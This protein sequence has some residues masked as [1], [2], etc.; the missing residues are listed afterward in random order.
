MTIQVSTD[1][2]ISLVGDCPSDDA[3]RLLQLLLAKPQAGLDWRGCETA[4]SA[5]IQ[6]LLQSGQKPKGPAKGLFLRTFL[7]PNFVQA[8]TAN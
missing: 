8:G 1:G 2:T 5:V 6:L 7:E 3:E 4:H